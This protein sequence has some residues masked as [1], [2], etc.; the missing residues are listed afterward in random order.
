MEKIV[1]LSLLFCS[2]LFIQPVQTAQAQTPDKVDFYVQAGAGIPAAPNNFTE[3]Y[4]IGYGFGAGVSY[5]VR[6]SVKLQLLGQY[7]RFSFDEDGA[8]DNVNVSQSV[9]GIDGA[10]A[11]MV[12]LMLNVIYEYELPGIP[13]S[14]YVSVGAGYLRAARDDFTITTPE[15]TFNIDQNSGSSLAVNG[16]VGLKRALND[17]LSVNLE[18]KFVTGLFI[19]NRTQYVPLSI[20]IIF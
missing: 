19:D 11:S 6:P 13:T 9:T 3:N 5:T 14:T 4:K 12:S 17:N 8:L 16:A 18:A 1:A 20:G 2:F 7:H 10:D 15:E